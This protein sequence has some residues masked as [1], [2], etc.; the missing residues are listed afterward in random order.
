M[1]TRTDPRPAT[2]PCGGCFADTPLD[3]LTP[4]PTGL[5]GGNDP[6]CPACTRQRAEESVPYGAPFLRDGGETRDER[7]EAQD[8]AAADFARW[9]EEQFHDLAPYGPDDAD[10]LAAEGG[11]L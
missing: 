8:A 9:L 11:A 7:R 4:H 1:T 3:Q 6:L 5:P 10:L 2:Y